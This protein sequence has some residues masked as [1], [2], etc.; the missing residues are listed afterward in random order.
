[1]ICVAT[2]T[3]PEK[4][5]DTKFVN[6]TR[7]LLARWRPDL[8]YY[9]CVV[10]TRNL[11]IALAGVFFRGQREQMVFVLC[12][13]ICYF[14]ITGIC[15][16][17]RVMRVNWYDISTG[18][19]LALVGVFSIVFHTLQEQIK[20]MTFNQGET[21]EVQNLQDELEAYAIVLLLFITVFHVLLCALLV[22]CFTLLRPGQLE[23]QKGELEAEDKHLVASAEELADPQRQAAMKHLIHNVLDEKTRKELTLFFSKVK[24]ASDGQAVARGRGSVE[25]SVEAQPQT[26]SA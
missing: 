16:P 24:L 26:V 17:W 5:A 11:I 25:D 14:T 1:M 9:G 3:A 18:V 2:F 12:V 19:M 23:A 8:Y 6:R 22:W 4:N 10:I 15:Q 21:S 20:L 13:I 7:F